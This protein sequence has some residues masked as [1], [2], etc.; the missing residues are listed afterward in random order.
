M[1]GDLVAAAAAHDVV[2]QLAAFLLGPRISALVDRDDELRRL[3]Q[4]IE[5]FGFGGF[6]SGWLT[7][8]R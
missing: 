6:H 5:E 1:D 8:L 4:E 3:L 2:P 7:I